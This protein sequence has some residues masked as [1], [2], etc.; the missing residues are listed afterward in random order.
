MEQPSLPAEVGMEVRVVWE[1][2]GC[3][4]LREERAPR[5]VV[6]SSA[7]GR[8]RLETAGTAEGEA[9]EAKEAREVVEVAVPRL[10]CSA[11]IR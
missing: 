6:P 2:P 3:R 7:A 5:E 11:S 9:E 10:A 4:V 1:V 8:D